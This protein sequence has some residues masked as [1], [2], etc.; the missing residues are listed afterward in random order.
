MIF[1]ANANFFCSPYIHDVLLGRWF[2]FHSGLDLFR[3]LIFCSSLSHYLVHRKLN[4]CSPHSFDSFG[5]TLNFVREINI[6]KVEGIDPLIW[7]LERY[8]YY[9]LVRFSKLPMEP[10]IWLLERSNNSKLVRIPML[11][12][13]EPLIWQL[14]ISNN[15]KF[16]RFAKLG[17][18]PQN[19]ICFSN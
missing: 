7:L 1:F 17:G 16:V 19:L 10:I 5:G 18:I 8:K 4:F 14:E 3:W 13:I 9:K 6:E 11:L 12:G 15:S 2:F